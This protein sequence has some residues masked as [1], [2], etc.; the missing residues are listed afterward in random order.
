M[1]KSI[2]Y[3]ALSL[4]LCSSSYAFEGRSFIGV[5]GTFAF[6]GQVRNEE[7]GVS[8]EK[9][10]TMGFGVEGVGGYKMLFNNFFGLRFYADVNYYWLSHRFGKEGL[11]DVNANADVLINFIPSD[12]FSLGV[13]AGVQA[14]IH[15]WNGDASNR[16][17]QAYDSVTS[18]VANYEVEYSNLF[19]G[20]GLNAGLTM[21]FGSNH[22]IDIFA[23]IPFLTDT[24]YNYKSTVNQGNNNTKL[25]ITANRPFSA[26]LRYIY[27]FGGA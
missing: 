24:L 5:G 6:A 3:L 13:Y 14:G 10:S 27:S 12:F 8:I 7:R 20:L 25:Y 18:I 1:K 26:G 15:I 19:F 11:F 2:S 21:G 23:K 22:A 4:G 17:K 16:A 9:E